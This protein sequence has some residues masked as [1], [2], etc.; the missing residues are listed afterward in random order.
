MST[1]TEG[2]RVKVNGT[3]GKEFTNPDE[4][5][6]AIR[7]LEGTVIGDRLMYVEVQLDTDPNNWNNTYLFEHAELD[8]LE[9]AHPLPNESVKS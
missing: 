7:G 8:V 3:Y 1:F 9:E 6:R 4:T 5:V 2:T